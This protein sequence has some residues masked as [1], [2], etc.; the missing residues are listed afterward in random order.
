VR[1]SALGRIKEARSQRVASLLAECGPE[2]AKCRIEAVLWLPEEISAVGDALAADPAI[3]GV[4]T[5]HLR[6]SG[7]FA[8]YA[9]K[10]D[11]ELVRTA[12]FDAAAAMNRIYRVYG[13]GE[14]PRYPKIDAGDFNP[15]DAGFGR[16]VAEAMDM[17]TLGTAKEAPVFEAPLQ[18]ALTLLYLNERELVRRST[19]LEAAENAAAAA[20]VKGVKWSKYPY[21]AILV[22]G[23]GPNA[24]GKDIGNFGKLRTM[25]A[26]QLYRERKAPFIIVSG[27]AMH[28]AHTDVIEAM[29][30]KRELI[31]R[32]GVPA[33]AVLID[34]EITQIDR[35]QGLASRYGV[36][37]RYVIDTH[38][39]MPIISPPR[40]GSARRW[41]CRR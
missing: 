9:A 7:A 39:P 15:V 29:G 26:A 28:P 41:A 6:P 16:L 22:L 36:R 1:S 31:E 24:A 40:T 30:M 23:N 5:R 27:G 19:P 10:S 18:F 2:D 14:A 17:V 34:P 32:Y 21:A 13:L 8:R 25:R 11:G 33:S 3:L 4:A 20:E 38:T 35:Y 12:W 37:I